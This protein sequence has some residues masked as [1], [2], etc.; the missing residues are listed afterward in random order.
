[1]PLSLFSEKTVVLYFGEKNILG[2][3][4]IAFCHLKVQEKKILVP[5]KYFVGLKLTVKYLILSI[6][7]DG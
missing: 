6:G 2:Q 4:T 1:V 3:Y 7:K 5:F